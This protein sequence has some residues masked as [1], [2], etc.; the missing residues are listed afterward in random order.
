MADDLYG[1]GAAFGF[2]RPRFGPVVARC[3]CPHPNGISGEVRV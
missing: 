2:R 3:L 1:F